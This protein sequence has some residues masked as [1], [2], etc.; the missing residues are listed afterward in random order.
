MRLQVFFCFLTLGLGYL[1][2]EMVLIERLVLF[3]ANPGYAVAV[4]LAGLLFVSGW[5]SA[6]AGRQLRKGTSAKRLACLVRTAGRAG[7]SLFQL[8]QPQTVVDSAGWGLSKT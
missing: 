7:A 1:F 2:M 8:S 5:G 3:L 4:V 6:W